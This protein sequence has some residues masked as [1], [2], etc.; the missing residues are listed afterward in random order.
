[1]VGS[2]AAGKGGLGPAVA[3]EILAGVNL[4]QTT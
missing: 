1:V 2:Q 3:F 4:L